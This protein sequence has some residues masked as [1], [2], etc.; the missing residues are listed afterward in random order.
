MPRN[1][2][3]D[4]SFCDDKG[5]LSITAVAASPNGKEF[6]ELVAEGLDCEVL[7]WQMDVEE[8]TAA[9]IISNALNKGQE[10]ALRTTEL[11][12]VAVLKG[13]IIA[14]KSKNFGERVAFQ[15][16]R[17]RVRTQLDL[18]ADDP[19]LPE[20]FDYLISAGVGKNS[21]IDHLLEFGGCF[22]DSKKRQLR[23]AAFGIANKISE[24]APWTKIAV[25]KRAYR[26]KPSHGF[27][28]CPESLWGEFE[29]H[30]LRL[31]EDLLR[32]FHGACSAYL[33]KLSPQSRNKLLANIDV[34]AADTFF[35][36]ADPKHK[37]RVPEIE[38]QLLEATCKYL[39]PLGIKGTEIPR[40]ESEWMN[41]V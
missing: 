13:E 3:K 33:E 29:Y 2:N 12:A 23:F 28:P 11:T 37:N 31:L 7:S 19:D 25:I 20:L 15:T 24:R 14:Q 30:L 40:C 18:A 10:I 39:E 16:V 41:F 26:K 32:F 35:A 5:R 36:A 4:I 9:S 22:V 21:Y 27:C 8:P 17:E 34:T 1:D 6:E 38:K